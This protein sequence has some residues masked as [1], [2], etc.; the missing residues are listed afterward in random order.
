MLQVIC[1]PGAQLPAL[2]RPIA[3]LAARPGMSCLST[4]RSRNLPLW[5]V[6]CSEKCGVGARRTVTR[7]AMVLSGVEVGIRLCFINKMEERSPSASSPWTWT[8]LWGPRGLCCSCERAG[9]R[10]PA[11][12]SQAACSFQRSPEEP[13]TAHQEQGAEQNVWG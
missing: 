5:V 4:V 12:Q 11:S 1:L 13:G 6:G 8:C 9:R 2:T 3:A 10:E 7:L